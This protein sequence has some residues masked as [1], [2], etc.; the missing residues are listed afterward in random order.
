MFCLH[1][2]L[3]DTFRTHTIVTIALLLFLNDFNETEVLTTSSHTNAKPATAFFTER[4]KEMKRN[5]VH[6][7]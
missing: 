5:N 4:V 6:L 2:L 3:A 1:F 7:H